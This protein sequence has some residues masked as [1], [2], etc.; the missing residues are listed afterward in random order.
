MLITYRAIYDSLAAHE[1]LV[2]PFAMGT[3][4][5][6]LQRLSVTLAIVNI[7]AMDFLGSLQ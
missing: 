6:C 4:T 3:L 1:V 7:Q 5:M 2:L